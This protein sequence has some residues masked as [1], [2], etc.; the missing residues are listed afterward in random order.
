MAAEA[1]AT[2]GTR[3]C[4]RGPGAGANMDQIPDPTLPEDL[5]TIQQAARRFAAE[6]I[7]PGYMERDRTGVI[8]RAL[9]RE[10]GQLG[11][12]APELPEALGG[13][14][15]PSLTSGL[16]AE[17][18]G[19][20]DMNV[21]YLQI[22]GSL[23]GAIVAAHAAPDLAREWVG[24]IAA[25]EAI[26]ALGLTEPRGG[27]DAANI[28]LSARWTGDRYV[29]NGEKSSISMGDQADAVVLFARTGSVE[30]RARGVTAFLVPMDTP[31]VTTTRYTD[32]GS[33]AVGRSSIFFQDVEVPPDWRLA[34]EGKGFVQVMQ[35]FDF[36]RALIG[37]QVLGAAQAS[38]DESWGYIAE[39]RAFGAPIGANQGVS[40][41]LAEG[42]TMVAAARQLCHHTLRLR[43]AGLPHTAEAAMCKW[44]CPRQ[45]ST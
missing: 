18:I 37:L 5:A 1:L 39:R 45:R 23:C 16:I 40:F 43:D 2:G 28:A 24:R 41:P 9:V 25:G 34:E 33:H 11:L 29:L 8:D 31:G 36:S 22:V 44:L 30:E 6:R 13:L 12:I 42:E 38:L 15:L 32:L 35:G 7:A 26:V 21:A 19:Y 4:D 10:I 20:A 3:A 17:A 27:S 14:G